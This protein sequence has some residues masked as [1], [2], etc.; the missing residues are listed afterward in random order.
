LVHSGACSSTYRYIPVHRVSVLVLS[1]T[2]QYIM[3]HHG[4]CNFDGPSFRYIRIHSSTSPVHLICCRLLLHP[5]GSLE[6]SRIAAAEEHK[7]S[8]RSHLILDAGTAAATA[9]LRRILGRW[10]VYT[11]MY[12]PKINAPRVKNH[13]LFD[14]VYTGIYR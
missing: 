9:G 7:S 6:C 1:S 13:Q 12:R 10:E 3:V 4:L 11:S 14:A 5:A 2:Q 8:N